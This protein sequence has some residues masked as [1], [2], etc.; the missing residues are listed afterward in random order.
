MV[1]Y[2]YE[3]S[4]GSTSLTDTSNGSA[5]LCCCL[6][7]PA[8][9]IR[10]KKPIAKPGSKK[11]EALKKRKSVEDDSDSDT[12]Q[13]AKKMKEEEMQQQQQQSVAQSSSFQQ[14][15]HSSSMMLQQQTPSGYPAASSGSS[16]LHSRASLDLDTASDIPAEVIDELLGCL[17]D[18]DFS[19]FSEKQMEKNPERISTIASS[20][21]KMN[22]QD[23]KSLLCRLIESCLPHEREFIYQKYFGTSAMDNYRNGQ[24]MSQQQ[25]QQQQ[26]QQHQQMQRQLYAAPTDQFS[27][28]VGSS[29][30]SIPYPQTNNNNNN[31][32]NY[33]QS[34]TTQQLQL[35][36]Q[37]QQDLYDYFA[38][39]NGNNRPTMLMPQQSMNNPT[40]QPPPNQMNQQPMMNQG[41]Q[42]HNAPPMNSPM[43]QTTNYSQQPAVVSQSQEVDSMFRAIL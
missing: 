21:Q 2:L 22:D 6:I 30:N 25:Q 5:N 20:F 19:K 23:R 17:N 35:I 41:M 10:A 3:P 42:M 28:S 33:S 26:M 27:Q 43:A 9:T 13:S 1:I 14:Q 7:S 36:Q 18:T 29:S 37:H 15:Q 39:L 32:P 31:I 4:N 16:L 11:K 34:I 24:Q 12:P 40:M 38:M 8:F